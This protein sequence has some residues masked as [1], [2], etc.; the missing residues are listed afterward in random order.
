MKM[1]LCTLM[2]FFALLPA[3]LAQTAQ[4]LFPAREQVDAL[5]QNPGWSGLRGQCEAALRIESKPV[6]DFSPAPH[7]GPTGPQANSNNSPY[8]ALKTESM[9]AYRLAQCFDISKDARYSTKAE[10]LLDAWAHTTT[11]VGTDQGEDEFNF[12]FPY[13]LMGAYLL[14]QDSTWRRDDFSAFVRKIVVPTNHSNKPNNHGNW[15]VLLLASAGGYLNDPT[16]LGEARQRWLEL[17]RSQVAED[18]SLPLEVCR[19][20]TS[21]WCGGPTK[22]IRGIAY[23][24]YTLLPS[25]LAAEVFRNQG[26]DVYATPEGALLCEAYHQAA[27]WTLHPETFPYF[28]SNNGKLQDV[29]GVDYFFILQKRCPSADGA[30]VLKQFGDAHDAMGLRFLYGY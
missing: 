13:A 11:R 27:N 10:Q 14:R 1:K 9:A 3:T 23:T 29:Y 7:Y 18:G 17:M 28:A 4:S 20:D 24:H 25:T 22:G 19:S 5:R 2:V 8:R 12:N 30:A 21:N 26:K 6:A 16:T 15:G